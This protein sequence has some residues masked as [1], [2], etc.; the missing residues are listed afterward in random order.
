MNPVVYIAV[1]IRGFVISIVSFV[2]AALR[3]LLL[4]L[5]RAL[6][7]VLWLFIIAAGFAAIFFPQMNLINFVKNLIFPSYGDDETNR[8]PSSDAIQ[9]IEEK[10]AVLMAQ[11][12]KPLYP[13]EI[14]II[15]NRK[16]LVEDSFNAIMPWM[17]K[18]RLHH[19]RIEVRFVGEEGIDAGGL[20]RE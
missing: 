19:S 9:I 1:A 6:L 14:Q 10:R 11:L 3:S 17:G 13:P 2:L 4:G 12:N 7:T 16:R 18:S 8:N 5:T 20:T 15:V